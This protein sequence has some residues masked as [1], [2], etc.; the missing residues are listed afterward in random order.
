MVWFFISLLLVFWWAGAIQSG[1]VDGFLNPIS[2]LI[3]LFFIAF[4]IYCQKGINGSK[5]KEIEEAVHYYQELI[6]KYGVAQGEQKWQEY[7]YQ[8]SY[9]YAKEMNELTTKLSGISGSVSAWAW[10]KRQ[11]KEIL[12]RVDAY[13]NNGNGRTELP[14]NIQKKYKESS[15]EEWF[16]SE[17]YRKLY[18]QSS[19]EENTNKKI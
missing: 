19:D 16:N 1:F 3:I 6:E 12:E 11:R 2:L 10:S 17:E 18:S 14:T 9:E 4:I 8:H 7:L 13:R 15:L 5:R